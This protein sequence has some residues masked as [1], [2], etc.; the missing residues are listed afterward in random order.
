MSTITVSGCTTADIHTAAASAGIGGTVVFPAGV[1]ASDGLKV[2]YANQ[3]WLLDR[4]AIIKRTD[5]TTEVILSV[6]ADGFRLRGGELD[7]NRYVNTSVVSGIAA[8]G[9]SL[10]LQDIDL[11]SVSHWGISQTDASLKMLDCSVRKTGQ[12][13]VFWRIQPTGVSRNGPH[14]ERCNFSRFD[15]DDYID[16]GCICIVGQPTKRI[17][18]TRIINN[19]M[20]CYNPNWAAPKPNNSGGVGIVGGSNGSVITGNEVDGG[21]IG[22]SLGDGDFSVVSGNPVSDCGSYAVEIA[23]NSTDNS[24]TGNPI[25][26]CHI[27]VEVSGTS[28][29][30]KIIGNPNHDCDIPVEILSAPVYGNLQWGN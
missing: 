21:R 18:A 22:I 17:V 8:F 23:G 14:I 15:P 24:I 5:I 12:A 30:N 11:H 1:Y 6:E 19:R 20:V 7:G 25:Y 26:S 2:L 28:A 9:F 29:R 4:G 3:T 10:D 13:G 27:G 16:S